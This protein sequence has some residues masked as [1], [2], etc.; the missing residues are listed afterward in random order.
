MVLRNRSELVAV[1]RLHPICSLFL[2]LINIIMTMC[3]SNPLLLVVS[4]LGGAAYC[5]WL[6]GWNTF[7]KNLKVLLPFWLVIVMG[8]MLLSH[9]GV[10]VLFY[11]NDYAV[12]KEAMIYGAVI[13][14]MLSAAFLWVQCFQKI[15]TGEKLIYLFGKVAPTIGLTFSMTLHYVDL[16]KRRMVIIQQ[17]QRGMGR[18]QQEG[19]LKQVRQRGKEYSILISWSMENAID[20]S[21]AMTARGYGLKK[22]TCYHLYQFTT[23]D[24]L[25]MLVLAML[26]IAAA[27][28]IFPYAHRVYY[29][30]AIVWPEESGLLYG[31]YLGY[32]G[33]MLFPLVIDLIGEKNGNSSIS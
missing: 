19:W 7:C 6:S 20:T 2:F 27:I 33:L 24:G 1:A 22:R 9:N 21:D 17:A 16:L 29:Y 23:R 15:C 4:F 26:G 13:G 5:I 30:P 12:T 10:H 8:N 31:C 18:D 3:M 11:I 28:A 25:V 32:V 14:C